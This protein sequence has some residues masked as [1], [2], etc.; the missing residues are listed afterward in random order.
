[1]F[2]SR[3]GLG[4]GAQGL[5]GSNSGVGAIPTDKVLQQQLKEIT[6]IFRRVYRIYAHAWFQHRE[7][8]WRVEGKTGLYGFFKIVCDEYGLIQPENYTIPP[9]AEGQEPESDVSGT[10]EGVQAPTLL[11]RDATAPE[12]ER[13]T[14]EPMGNSVLAAGDTT[15][16]HRHTLSD[17]SSSV[18]TVIQEEAEEDEPTDRAEPSLERQTTRLRD[19]AESLPKPGQHGVKVEDEPI[20]KEEEVGVEDVAADDELT[21]VLGIERSETIK[22]PKEESVVEVDSSDSVVEEADSKAE[23]EN[24]HESKASTVE[25]ED[26]EEQD[27]KVEAM[28]PEDAGAAEAEEAGKTVAD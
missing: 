5:G 17:R 19:F 4:S 26:K 16:R 28:D 3:L 23:R 25:A 2:P 24:D 22:P 7:M 1:M 11:K 15:K 6:N 8:F 13:E 12:G 21:P 9:E 18:T 10:R 14:P 20:V 27:K